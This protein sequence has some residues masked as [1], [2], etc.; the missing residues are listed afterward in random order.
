MIKNLQFSEDILKFTRNL[1]HTDSMV[2]KVLLYFDVFNYPLLK[3]EIFSFLPVNNFGKEELV[4]SLNFLVNEN[5]ISYYE[6]YYFLH[7]PDNSHI[8]RRIK[9][10]IAAVKMMKTARRFSRLIGYFPFV[11]C[12]CISGSLSKG[13]I[14]K[15]ADIDYF[16]ITKPGRLWIARTLLVLF[17]KIFLLNYRK[18]FCVN[19]FIDEDHLEIQD[20]NIFTATELVTL[21]PMNNLHLFYKFIESNHWV[22]RFLPNYNMYN[23]KNILTEKS[24]FKTIF[25]KLLNGT[26]GEWLDTRFMHLT[27]NR[28]KNK[29]PNFNEEEFELSMRSRKYVSKHHPNNFQKRVIS[30]LEENKRQFETQF[31]LHLQN[32]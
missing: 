6:G 23:F 20:K 8:Q 2:I 17:K 25:E 7:K 30:K 9:G 4:T 14:D 16:I 1:S 22:N 12:V 19:Y 15:D 13:Y 11:R 3:D 32:G 5:Y 28:W 31:E 27:I 18:Y 29:F 10:N 24:Y 21:I 26:F